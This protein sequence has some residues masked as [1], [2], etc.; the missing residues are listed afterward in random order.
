MTRTELNAAELAAIEAAMAER[1][2]ASVGYRYRLT[3]GTLEYVL[4]AVPAADEEVDAETA[5]AELKE[6]LNEA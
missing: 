6:A 4:A 2:V 5:L 3:D 1:P